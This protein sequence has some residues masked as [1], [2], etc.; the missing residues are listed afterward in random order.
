MDQH[1]FALIMERFDSV[2]KQ[3]DAQTTM[4]REHIQKDERYYSMIDKHQTYINI[5][6]KVVSGLVVVFGM[7][8]AWLG[9]IKK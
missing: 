4:I 3:N 6:A 5:V 8:V 1:E 9:L 2:D 7:V